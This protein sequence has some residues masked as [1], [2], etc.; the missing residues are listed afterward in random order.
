M[1]Q[2]PQMAAVS[3]PFSANTVCTARTTASA[4]MPRRQ[5]T[6]TRSTRGISRRVR[7]KCAFVRQPMKTPSGP[8][9]PANVPSGRGAGRGNWLQRGISSSKIAAETALASPM[10]EMTQ[11]CRAAHASTENLPRTSVAVVTTA[12]APSFSASFT[13]SALAPPIWPE[14]RGITN[15]PASSMQTTAGSVFLLLT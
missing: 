6:P 10:S 1:E 14:S 13:A 3:S 5:P 8:L 15:R 7:A 12:V 4:E 2:T 11:P 9:S